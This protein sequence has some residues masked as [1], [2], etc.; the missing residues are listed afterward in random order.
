MFRHILVFAALSAASCS[1]NPG[2][3]E[4]MLRFTSTLSGTGALGAVTFH[5]SGNGINPIDGTL[6]VGASTSV[7]GLPAGTGYSIEATA[8]S[9]DGKTTCSGN[10]TFA[11]VAGGETNLALTLQ[12]KSTVG[13]GTVRITGAFDN[14]PAVTAIGSDRT[15]AA[16]GETV[17]VF[18]SYSDLDG[19]P[20][21][22]SWRQD[23]IV[24]EF[25]QPGQKNTG[26]VCR[27]VGLTTLTLNVG[28]S[29][30]SDDGKS[31]CDSDAGFNPDGASYVTCTGHGA[32]SVFCGYSASDGG[33]D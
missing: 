18:S 21:C 26:F 2:T 31:Q 30:L 10:A 32:I 11:I 22:F 3:G 28:D 5:I 1:K 6:N 29:R 4:G 9:T 12:C 19:D 15:S 14:C 24:G 16:I 23:P 8:N 17:G 27:A 7:G 20:V 25:T 13:S 33:S